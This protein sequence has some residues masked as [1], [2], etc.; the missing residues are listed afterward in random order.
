[1]GSRWGQRGRVGT[2]GEDSPHATMCHSHPLDRAQ[3]RA[4]LW[5]GVCRI[6]P[7]CT[8][9]LCAPSITTFRRPA[10]PRLL[11]GSL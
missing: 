4:R 7:H 6:Y 9:V 8:R 5:G 11:L 1:M 3:K 2:W 10:G